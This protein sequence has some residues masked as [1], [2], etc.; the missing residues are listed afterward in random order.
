[1]TNGDRI[2]AMTDK[3]LAETIMCPRK[4]GLM[5]VFCPTANCK[6]CTLKWLKQPYEGPKRW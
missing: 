5:M 3:E 1:M 6:K 2:R 4:L